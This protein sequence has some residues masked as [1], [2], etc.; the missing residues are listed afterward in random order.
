MKGTDLEW[1]FDVG[2][3][4]V[5]QRWPFDPKMSLTNIL[6]EPGNTRRSVVISQD[7]YSLLHFHKARGSLKVEC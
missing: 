5:S 4:S 7:L 6:N 1:H 3:L 2:S